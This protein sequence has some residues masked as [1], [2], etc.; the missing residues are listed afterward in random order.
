MESHNLEFAGFRIRFLAI[1]IDG[2]LFNILF[3]SI[4]S[5]NFSFLPSLKN[6]SNISFL[7]I[8]Q[9]LLIWDVY[10]LSD[11]F[12]YYLKFF[13]NSLI[14]FVM[15]LLFWFV[16]AATPGKMLFRVKIV[17]MKTGKK[18]SKLQL[19]IRYLCY[20]LSSILMLGFLWVI[21]D[22]KK[23]GWHDKLSCTAVVR[24]KTQKVLFYGTTD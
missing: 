5:N 2:I 13:K 22:K 8:Q 10:G 16:F 4:F 17:D 19:I 20:F 7:D 9:S 15:T 12:V 23:Q 18:P 3:Y 24:Q 14:P 11:F 21:F 1:I 6:F